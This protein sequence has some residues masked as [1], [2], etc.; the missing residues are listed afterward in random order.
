MQLLK[1][2]KLGDNYYLTGFDL[3]ILLEPCI[4]CAMALIHSRVRRV[5][6]MQKNNFNGALNTK[7]GIHH[8]KS[9]NHH[10]NAFY[11]NKLW[12]F[13]KYIDFYVFF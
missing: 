11:C 9:L 12:L 5:F 7:L 1:N 2:C 3:F 8:L 6:Y 13:S 10:Y 4:M